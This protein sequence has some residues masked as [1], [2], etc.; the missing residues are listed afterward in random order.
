MS[1]INP[2]QQRRLTAVAR[3][4]GEIRVVNG[5]SVLVSEVRRI[6]SG[7]CKVCKHS[8]SILRV[9]LCTCR[10]HGGGSEQSRWRQCDAWKRSTAVGAVQ[11]N[12]GP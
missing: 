12:I 10:I 5:V 7:A 9:S 6:E 4:R 1:G 3:I 2:H 8:G 11:V